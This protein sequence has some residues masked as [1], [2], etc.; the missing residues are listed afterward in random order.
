MATIRQRASGSWEVIIRR[1]GL[2]SKA[3]S[4]TAQTKAEAE[5]YAKAIEAMLDKGVIPPELIEIGLTESAYAD[6]WLRQYLVKVHISSADNLILNGLLAKSAGWRGDR[7]N[8]QWAQAWLDEMKQQ[9]R[10]AP[11]TIRHKVGAYARFLDWCRRNGWIVVNPLRHLPKHYAQYPPADGV[12]RADVERDRRLEPG[13]Y[14]RIVALLTY[15][16]RVRDRAAWLL[17]FTLAVET[18]MRLREIYTLDASQ[19]NLARRT[20]FLDKTKNGDKR[21]VPLSS[22]ALAALTD[23]PVKEGLIFPFWDGRPHRLARVTVLLSHKWARIAKWAAC[24]DLH[25]HDLR[26]EAVSRMFEL[27]QWSDAKIMKVIGHKSHQMLNRYA[28]LRASDL[29]DGMW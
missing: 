6:Y 23:W 19:V 5:A 15:D 2:L 18:A 16:K 27:T 25:F 21:Q 26:H 17:L 22:I 13:E 9:D 29:A 3:H 20:I 7:L 4:A 12:K 14:E 28:N 1:K 10:I 11:S 24:E 8:M